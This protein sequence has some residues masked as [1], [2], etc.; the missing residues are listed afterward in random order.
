MIEADG[1]RQNL[2]VKNDQLIRMEREIIAIVMNI[3]VKE[4][5]VR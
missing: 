3:F 5:M 2:D 1:F 4:N